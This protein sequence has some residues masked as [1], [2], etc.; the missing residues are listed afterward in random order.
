MAINPYSKGILQKIYNKYFYS[1]PKYY[2]KFYG[3]IN[4]PVP[5][6]KKI[7][8][9]AAIGDMYL[10]PLEILMYHLLRNKGIEVYYLIYDEKI[11]LIELTTKKIIDNQGKDYFISKLVKKAIK[12]L[13]AAKVDFDFIG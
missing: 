4:H 2:R 9:Y 12:N 5:N 13:T 3:D 1:L 10:S 6:N 7:L 11:P 8:I